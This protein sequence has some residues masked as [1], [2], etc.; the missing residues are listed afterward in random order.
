M[1]IFFLHFFQY[2]VSFYNKREPYFCAFSLI[3]KLPFKNKK[4]ISTVISLLYEEITTFLSNHCFNKHNTRSLISE[5]I[6][7][8]KV[9]K[10]C[11]F[12][13]IIL[14]EAKI[15]K[16]SR[17]KSVGIIGKRIGRVIGRKRCQQSGTLRS[18]WT[19]RQQSFSVD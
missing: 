4:N 17:S 12:G 9:K 3:L 10:K 16:Q 1:E 8:S 11:Q 5:N 15:R 14:N 2:L 7:Y 13:D 18:S 19:S 6:V